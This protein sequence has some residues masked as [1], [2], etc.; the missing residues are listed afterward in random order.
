MIYLLLSARTE[1]R[2]AFYFN[3]LHDSQFHIVGKAPVLSFTRAV[4]ADVQAYDDMGVLRFMTKK[5]GEPCKRCG[6]SKWYA[7]GNC[8]Q[9]SKEA[10]SR[11]RKVNLNSS[12]QQVSTEN[13]R[14]ASRRWKKNNRERANEYNKR[15]AKANPEAGRRTLRR[16]LQANPEAAAANA[17]RRRTRETNAGGSYSSSEWKG[18]I[19]HYGHRCLCCNRDDVKLTADHVIPVSKGGT[20]NIDNIQPLCKSCNSK[21]RD[22]SID[23]RPGKGLGRWIQ[24]KLFG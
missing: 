14:A 19:E 18:L 20:S 7:S 5:N 11:W 13:S 8:V 17:A 2:G 10:G 24:R 23:Y 4:L 12:H 9:C 1:S 3:S 16:W 22:K 15:W 6:T 21:K